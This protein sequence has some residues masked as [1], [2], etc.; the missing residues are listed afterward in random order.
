MNKKIYRVGHLLNAILYAYVADEMILW[1]ISL[2]K[3]DGRVE[4]E[5]LLDVDA[6]VTASVGQSKV[7]TMH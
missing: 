3:Q 2:W 7:D 6:N 4:H 1:P 5:F